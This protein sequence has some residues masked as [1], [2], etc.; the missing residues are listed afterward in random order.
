MNSASHIEDVLPLT[1]SQEFFLDGEAASTIGSIHVYGYRLSGRVD[2]NMAERAWRDI[3]AA[4]PS[5]RTSLHVLSPGRVFQAVH[6]A[7]QPEFRY[8]DLSDLPRQ[9]REDAVRAY[10]EADSKTLFDWRKPPLLRLALHR[11]GNEECILSITIDHMIFDGWSLGLAVRDFLNACQTQSTGEP[12][13]LPAGPSVRE[14]LLWHRRQDVA[15]ALEWFRNAM[16]DVPSQRLPFAKC[17]DWPEKVCATDVRFLSFTD[18]EQHGLKEGAK[19]LGV[20]LHAVF[21][22]AWALLLSHCQGGERAYFLSTAAIRPAEV[23]GIHSLFG[24]L[25]GVIPFCLACPELGRVKE[26]LGQIRS[27]QVEA[28]AYQS[29]PPRDIVAIQKQVA[30]DAQTSCIVFQNMDTG[31]EQTDGDAG[32]RITVSPGGLVSRSGYP[33]VVGAQASP[34]LQLSFM[35]DTRIFPGPGIE[36][37][38]QLL[39]GIMLA[40]PEN[41]EARLAD[42]C[43]LDT[44]RPLFRAAALAAP[45]AEPVCPQASAVRRAAPRLPSQS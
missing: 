25:L 7:A 1:V 29:A 36:L 14:Y 11:L 12:W 24:L 30:P 21:Q 43:A 13:S 44:L 23:Q 41:A 15:K 27:Y 19:R 22:G 34:G 8:Y 39:K 28:M 3:V 31:T 37:L 10:Q 26:W 5:L 20:T 45:Q 40:L 17:A 33:L 35:Y 16:G 2:E 4:Y 42:V 6:H 32:G 18:L 9:E 38:A